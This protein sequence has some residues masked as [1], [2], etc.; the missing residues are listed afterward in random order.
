MYF[1][2][3]KNEILISNPLTASNTVDGFKV[4]HTRTNADLLAAC[5]IGANVTPHHSFYPYMYP[6]N[7]HKDRVLIAIVV[8]F[9]NK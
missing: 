2:A 4:K 8:N 7:I 1:I 9:A 6:S 3:N 5:T